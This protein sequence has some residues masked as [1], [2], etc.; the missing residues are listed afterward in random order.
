M[1]DPR[2]NTFVPT[3]TWY[4]DADKYWKTVSSNMDGML[5]GLEIVHEPDVRD[6]LDFLSKLRADPELR[7]GSKYACDC[8]AGIGRVTKHFLLKEFETVDLVEQNVDFLK[9]AESA[10]LLEEKE[11]GRIGTLYPVGLQA[12][13]PTPGRYDMIWCQ[14]VLSH[15]TD[16]DLA[17]FLKRCAEGL[18][19]GGL[20]C[21][22]ENVASRGY[23]LDSEDSSVTRSDIIFE[24][25]FEKAGMKWA[26]AVARAGTWEIILTTTGIDDALAAALAAA[27]SLVVSDPDVAVPD[28]AEPDVAVPDVAEPDVA[29]PDVAVPDVAEPDVAEPDVAVPDVAVPDVAEPD[30]AVP[31]VSDPDVAEPDVAEPDVAVPDVAEPDVAELDPV[32]LADSELDDSELDPAEAEPLDGHTE[33]VGG[34]GGGA[35]A[36]YI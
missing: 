2:R 28:V 26:G 4:E 22:K 23:V 18:S 35:V 14:W 5:G 12:F 3:K 11:S 15:L 1:T 36:E 29:E 21:V 20:I 10:Y 24:K 16:R 31:D 7:F 6:S 30:V 27:S 13:T 17:E 8:G 19:P 33:W 32:A 25:V 34:G 9:E